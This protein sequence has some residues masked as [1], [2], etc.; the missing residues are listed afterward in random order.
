M[1]IDLTSKIAIWN[2]VADMQAESDTCYM[3]VLE[4][5]GGKIRNPAEMEQ[6]PEWQA[7]DAAFNRVGKA[8]DTF[9]PI[10]G[11]RLPGHDPRPF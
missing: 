3:K 4:T 5:H 8:I 10:I 6:T 11:D 9:R 2:H 7:Y 1:M